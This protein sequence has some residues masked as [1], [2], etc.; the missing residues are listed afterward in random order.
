LHRAF[1]TALTAASK[2]IV[3]AGE[4]VASRGIGFFNRAEYKA[5]GYLTTD[6]GS[7]DGDYIVYMDFRESARLLSKLMLKVAPAR[8]NCLA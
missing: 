3:L 5:A 7:D 6:Q 1:E 8:Y 4:G 2:V